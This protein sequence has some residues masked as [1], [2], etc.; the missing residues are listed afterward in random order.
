MDV[1]DLAA[2]GISVDQSDSSPKKS[3]AYVCQLNYDVDSTIPA[4]V[5]DALV[6]KINGKT[7]FQLDLPRKLDDFATTID[8]T[9]YFLKGQVNTVEF[10]TV[11]YD[12]ELFGGEIKTRSSI[13]LRF[14]RRSIIRDD[15]S[16]REIFRRTQETWHVKDHR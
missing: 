4:A 2:I 14:G 6:L 16:S 1:K 9:Q 15:Y 5:K 3:A 12:F 7:A 10:Q 11:V 13:K 8:V